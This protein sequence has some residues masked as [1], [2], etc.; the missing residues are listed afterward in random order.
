MLINAMERM[1]KELLEEYKHRLQLKCTCS[2]CL[3]DILALSL[4]KTTPRYVTN[5]EKVMYVKAELIDKQEITSLL[6][7]LAECAKI[8]SDNPQC[9]NYK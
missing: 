5:M 9:D 6:V 8:V 3:D 4:N 1:M 2:T 7:I